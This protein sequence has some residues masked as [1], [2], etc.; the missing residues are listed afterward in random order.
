MQ[1]RLKQTYLWIR[2]HFTRKRGT[3]MDEAMSKVSEGKLEEALAIYDINIA[4]SKEQRNPADT[5]ELLLGKSLTL[6]LLSRFK[7]SALSYEKAV[8]ISQINESHISHFIDNLVNIFMILDSIHMCNLTSKDRITCS[9]CRGIHSEPTTLSCGHTICL[10]CV[11][12]LDDRGCIICSKPN[13]ACGV[14]VNVI[15][16]EII[17]KYFKNEFEA[18]CR[19]L[20]GNALL[21][22]GKRTQALE[23]Y[24]EAVELGRKYETC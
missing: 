18:S 12:K 23:K 22:D 24:E 1:T 11:A 20:E 3:R 19:R 9:V 14:K 10:N 7:E 17:R 15:L 16:Q 8:S 6:I 13:S 5:F 4:T 2:K 21:K